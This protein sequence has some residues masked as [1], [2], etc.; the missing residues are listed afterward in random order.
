MKVVENCIEYV[1]SV[2]ANAESGHDWFHVERVWRMSKIIAKTEKCN[3]L[4]VE[5]GALLH[6]IADPKFHNGDENLGLELSRNFLTTQNLPQ[7]VIQ[8]I[9]FIVENVS[10]SKSLD[11]SGNSSIELFIVQDAD[12]LDAIGA[13]GV[14]RTFNYGGYRNRKLYDPATPPTVYKNKS[15]YRKNESPTINHFYEKLLKLKDMMRTEKGKFLAE[16]RH[17]FM[18]E[19][20][21]QFYKEWNSEE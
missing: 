21:K 7:D 2:L 11:N 10:F 4:V 19:F 17:L 3:L 6:D 15:D 20:L 12:R 5:L 16:E 18:E 1:K 8:K 14:A 9:V 13:I